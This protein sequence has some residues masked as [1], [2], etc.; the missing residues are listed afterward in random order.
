MPPRRRRK[1][2][3]PQSEAARLTNALLS[4]G[5]SK[6]QVAEILGRNSAIVSHFYTRGPGSGAAYTQALH[7]VVQEVQAGGPRDVASLKT[8]AG[9][10]V[11][12]RR[13]KT[14]RIARV[15]G[16]DAVQHAGPGEEWTSGIARAGKQ[17]IASGAS[18]LKPIV[19]AAAADPDGVVAFTVRASKGRF[20][21]PSD[22]EYPT[23]RAHHIVERPDGTEERS[24]GNGATGFDAREF[25]DRVTASGGDVTAALTGWMVET[26]RL[27]EGAKISHLE[28]RGWKRRS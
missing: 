14:G 17:H 6:R 1:N 19:D 4:E 21:M 12:R 23:G 15:R 8:L 5:F 26:G 13:T 10:H 11:T 16:K 7:A 3:P 18:R 22:R 28:L 27:A 25:Q 24:Y 20:L 2:A 9:Q